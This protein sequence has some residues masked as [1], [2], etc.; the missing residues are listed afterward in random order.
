MNTFFLLLTLEQKTSCFVIDWQAEMTGTGN[1]KWFRVLEF[2]RCLI[3]WLVIWKFL[4]CLPTGV[5]PEEKHLILLTKSV[6]TEH[7]LRNSLLQYNKHLLHATAF[8]ILGGGE[9]KPP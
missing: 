9:D 6:F 8:V 5:P 3:K 1:G 4:K 2:P 7:K